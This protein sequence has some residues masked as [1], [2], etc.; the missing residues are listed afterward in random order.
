MKRLE[1][2]AAVEIESAG[3]V[4]TRELKQHAADLALKLAEERIRTRMD[5]NSEAALIDN[6]VAE[7]GRQGSKN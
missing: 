7:L 4:A 2:Q 3:K 1:S 5:S 6:F